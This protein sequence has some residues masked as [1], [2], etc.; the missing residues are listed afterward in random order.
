[1]SGFDSWKD[2]ERRCAMDGRDDS[3]FIGWWVNEGV[4]RMRSCADV[5]VSFLNRHYVPMWILIPLF[6]RCMT[7]EDHMCMLSPAMIVK[8]C[9]RDSGNDLA[10]FRFLVERMVAAKSGES[11]R[12]YTEEDV[13]DEELR[14]IESECRVLE[15]LGMSSLA[16]KARCV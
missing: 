3:K 14:L 15:E 12:Q 16:A 8:N 13:H 6:S 4:E 9:G 1:M 7:Y 10:L 5:D 11:L 2:L